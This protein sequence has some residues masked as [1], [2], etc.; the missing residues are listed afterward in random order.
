MLGK[1]AC[2][3]TL[4]QPPA[5][6]L[7]KLGCPCCWA[8]AGRAPGCWD[9]L[10]EDN[11]YWD[12]NPAEP[13]LTLVLS[14][15]DGCRNSPEGNWLIML[16]WVTSIGWSPSPTARRLNPNISSISRDL[17]LPTC[18]YFLR[19]KLQI[20]S[21]NFD[22]SLF[23]IIILQNLQIYETWIWLTDCTWA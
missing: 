16:W 19:T 5:E 9:E 15:G 11:P 20:K 17:F 21:S 2:T 8:R 13:V 23:F 4:L 12:W 10:A 22:V 7:E 3:I 1:P 18:F 14:S 6:P